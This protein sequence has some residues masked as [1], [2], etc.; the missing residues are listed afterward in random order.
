M[1]EFKSLN[2]VER[3][4]LIASLRGNAEENLPMY[5]DRNTTFVEDEIKDSEVISAVKSIPCHY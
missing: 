2:D 1:V 4:K 5:M 3:R